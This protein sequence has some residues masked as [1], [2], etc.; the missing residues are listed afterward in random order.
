MVGLLLL[1]KTMVMTMMKMMKTM[2]MEIIETMKMMNYNNKQY[3]KDED[4]KKPSDYNTEKL[5]N[6]YP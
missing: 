6:D 4:Y 3:N 2:K 5:N 1:P